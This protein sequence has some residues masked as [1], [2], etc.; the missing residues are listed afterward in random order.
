MA[1]TRSGIRRCDGWVWEHNW[2]DDYYGVKCADCGM[3]YAYG[4]EPW[5]PEREGMDDDEWYE[6]ED[7]GDEFDE[8]IGSCH[9][10]LD[11]GF[12]VCMAVGSEDCDMCP[13]NADLGKTPD[14]C[15]AELDL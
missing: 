9:A 15:E 2:H 13:F 5:A 4:C 10:F 7:D 3:F 8:A 11:G 1:D 12:Y 14:Q 6:G